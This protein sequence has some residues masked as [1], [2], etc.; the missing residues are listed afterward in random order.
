MEMTLFMMAFTKKWKLFLNE[1]LNAGAAFCRANYIDSQSRI[2]GVTG[3]IQDNEGI[4]ARYTR[5]TIHSAIHPNPF[6]GC[7]AQGV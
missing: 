7:K 2:T 6:Y 5:E 3:M 1:S 4:G